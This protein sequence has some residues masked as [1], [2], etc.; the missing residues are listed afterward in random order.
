MR[1]RFISFLS[2]ALFLAIS[3]TPLTAQ[4]L[5][6][7]I[8]A[9]GA[10]YSGDLSP[11]DL[12]LYFEDLNFAGGAYLRY[13]PTARFGIRVNGNFGRLSAEREM[14]ALNENVERVPIERNF[15]TKLTEFNAVLE[16]DLFYLGDR[17]RNFLAPYAYAGIGV[18]SFNP[19]SQIDG[20]YTELQPLR[21]EG[22]GL[23]PTRYDATPYEL[24]KT[25][26]VFGGGVRVRFAERIVLGLELGGRNTFTDYIDDISN[27]R[28]NYLDVISGPGGTL[29]GQFSNPAVT[30]PSEVTDLEYDRGGEFN[31]FYFVGGFTLGI[32]IGEGGSNKSGCYKF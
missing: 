30:N 18:L 31:D 28:V 19:E 1:T 14:V 24:T 10:L 29:A 4:G 5:E 13:R 27:T 7:G 25:I 16:Y 9:G 23:D 11:G 26:F 6:I 12:G 2:L 3:Y 22:Q 21:T 17:D 8:K 32:T 20:V 15:R